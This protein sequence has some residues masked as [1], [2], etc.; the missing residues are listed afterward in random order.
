MESN[1]RT[2]RPSLL[3][4]VFSGLRGR[5]V[6]GMTGGAPVLASAGGNDV[7]LYEAYPHLAGGGAPGRKSAPPPEPP[8]GEGPPDDIQ[9]DT[10]ETRPRKRRFKLWFFL[11]LL[12]LL[13]LLAGWGVLEMR[14][15]RLQA[16]IFAGMAKELTYRMDQGP[17]Q[18][19]RFPA[20]SPYDTRLGYANLPSYLDKLQS[21]G[22][23]IDAQARIS[24]KMVEMADRGLYATY[25]EKTKVGLEILDCRAQPL[26]TSK[27]PE[28]YYHEF[29][30]APP[31]LVQ[32][33]LFIENRE[34]LDPTYPR[35]NP[36]VEWD[37]FSQ[38]VFYKT[39]ST[40]GLGGE[41]RV[42]GG[43]TLAT[44]IE[45]YRHSP[46]GRTGSLQDKMIQMAS[47]TLRAY[48]DGEDTT[49]SRQKIV[50]DYLNTV[51]LSA[52]PGYGEVNGIGDGMWVWYGR[53]IEDTTRLLKGPMNTPEAATAYKEAL[54]LMIAQRRPAYYLGA[55]EQDLETLTN[56]HLRVLAQ[57]GVISPQLRDAALKVALHPAQ[58]SGVA[59]PGADAFVSRKA[60]NAVRNHLGYLV[61]D[62]RLYNLDRL[63]L[64]VVSTLDA[65]V[66]Q[67]VTDALRKLSDAE[68]AKEAGL[69]GKGLLGNG[70]PSQVVYSFTLMERGEHVNYLRVQTDNYDQPL[71]INEGAKLDLGSTAKLRTLVTYLDIVDQLHK[72]Y[73]PMDKIGLMG[74]E[75]DPKDRMS[76][77]AVE[78]FQQ[79]P[80]GADRGL[81]PML[82][83]AMERK[84][85]A[86]PGEAFFT[87]GGVHT[88][89]N[90]SKLDNS[91]IMTVTEALRNSTNLVFV[92][93]M[94]DVVRYYMFQ[95]PGS[96]AQLLADADDPRRQTYLARFA[97]NE[98]KVFLAKFWNKYK[99]K[100]SQE[101]VDLLFSG[102]RP[103][104]SKLAAAHRT[105]FPDASVADFGAFVDK[106]LPAS[107]D[108]DADRI[109]KMY[110]MYD[111]KNMSLA[112]RGYVA[113]VH[114]LELWLVSYLRTHPNAGW[115]E[116]TNASVQQRQDVY[117]WL[118]KTH[119]KHAQDKR[120]A[121]LIEV[122]AFLKIHAQ[123]KKMG[124]PFDSLVPSYATTLGASADRPAA[125]AELMGIIVNGGVRKPVERID[126]LHF[127]KDTPYETLVKRSK[128]GGKEQ[129]LSPDV[130]RTVADAIQGVVSNGTAKRVKTAFTQ[131]DGNVIAVGG[132]TGTG[133]QRF[134]VY[135]RGGRVIESRYVNRS[136]TF[137]FNIGERYFGSMTAYVHGPQSGNYD[138]TS[139]LPVQLL[140]NLAPSLMPM[141]EP[142]AGS[143]AAQ[144]QCV[145]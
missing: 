16:R 79:L 140:A 107:H 139:A 23:H 72:R 136:A 106:N 87:G 20:A 8:E 95:L 14:T 83:A 112:D 99:G 82:A 52:K 26:F 113:S 122:E 77:W 104:A 101:V 123:W 30:D 38:A 18:S 22:Y 66:Q 119:R 88:F 53:D 80:D 86:N 54:S 27:Y 135:A 1:R 36:A 116:V 58:G 134:E 143:V 13:V 39:L 118:F 37:R 17:S 137:V 21:R 128:G 3:S 24:P 32:S 130:A 131:S 117:S 28:R 15:S 57:A 47:A 100:T 98:G 61:G 76:Q 71:D 46:E 133:D 144:R 127:A 7:P 81:T 29:K 132:K 44:Q 41:G 78:Y 96:S 40:V 109:P 94:R 125:L 115:T 59:A 56:S 129:V 55:G 90:F 93:M 60:A 5:F 51:P 138:F 111:V 45:K 50:L 110:E 73:E 120:I 70:D 121:G 11:V 142:P 105:V 68:H 12:I 114:P 89:G 69:T 124:Y 91:K 85:S 9:D 48:Q 34:L 4:R 25:H 67:A 63:D 84:Y 141:I 6:F 145:R 97:D 33:L 126:S 75:T 74:I 65:G 31:L 92:R 42:A 49:K 43:S 62:S 35:R 102:V 10:P 108:M 64:S 19:I 103:M 2:E